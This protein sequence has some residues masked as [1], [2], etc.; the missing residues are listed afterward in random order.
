MKI[1]LDAFTSFKT[2]A[3][4]QSSLFMMVFPLAGCEPGGIENAQTSQTAGASTNPAIGEPARRAQADI[5]DLR[6]LDPTRL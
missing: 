1:S 2:R 3:V 6:D 4:I 5:A